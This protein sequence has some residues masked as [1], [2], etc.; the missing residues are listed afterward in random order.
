MKT[1]IIACNYPTYTRATR[2]ATT[3]YC[4]ICQSSNFL[5]N[6]CNTLARIPVF[7]R[8]DKIGVLCSIRQVKDE[9]NVCIRENVLELFQIR[10]GG[11]IASK[12]TSAKFDVEE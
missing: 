12:R 4:D 8:C 6:R 5:H 1:V 2:L 11:G 10:N 7:F 9:R 3:D